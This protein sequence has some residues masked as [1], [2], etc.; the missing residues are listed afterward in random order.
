MDLSGAIND[1]IMFHAGNAYYQPA[2]RFVLRDLHEQPLAHFGVAV[3]EMDRAVLIDVN[4][5]PAWLRKVVVKE[6]PNLIGV[7]ARQR[8]R[9]ASRG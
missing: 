3:V 7:S 4:S 8:L 6:M 9:R 5:A 2:A 1:R